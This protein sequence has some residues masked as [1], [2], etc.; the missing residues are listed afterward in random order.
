MPV[1]VLMQGLTLLLTPFQQLH[2]GEQHTG[3]FPE[4]LSPQEQ[5]QIPPTSP[6]LT[7]MEQRQLY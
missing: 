6:K 7:A 3:H 5:L 1:P 4:W 2:L